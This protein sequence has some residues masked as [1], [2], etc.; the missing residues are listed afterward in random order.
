M[1]A[2]MG[3]AFCWEW[4]TCVVRIRSVCSSEEVVSGTLAVKSQCNRQLC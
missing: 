4:Y 1:F 2:D 3:G